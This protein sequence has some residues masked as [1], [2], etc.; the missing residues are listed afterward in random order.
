MA[1]TIRHRLF[2]VK[3]AS[4]FFLFLSFSSAFFFIRLTAR[5]A[6]GMG[7][8]IVYFVENVVVSLPLH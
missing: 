7:M 5:G 8:P 3:K 4:A 2:P 6:W 1:K